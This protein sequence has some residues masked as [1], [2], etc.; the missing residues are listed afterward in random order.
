MIYNVSFSGRETLLTK[1][2]KEAV[3]K[4][5]EYL[6][7]GAIVGNGITEKTT[8]IAKDLVEKDLGKVYKKA[9]SPIDA[10]KRPADLN[11]AYRAAHAPYTVPKTESEAEIFS[12]AYQS[13][14]G[15]NV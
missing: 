11:E 3:S 2:V 1:P 10:A 4:A 8:Q 9:H 13:A 14:H 6:P 5:H 15:G 12:E 7:E